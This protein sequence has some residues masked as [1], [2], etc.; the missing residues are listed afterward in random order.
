MSRR[1]SIS[2]IMPAYNAA[3]YIREALDS[4]FAQT[5]QPDEV[6]VVENGST[7]ETGQILTEYPVRV[8]PLA[9]NIGPCLATNLAVAASRTDLVALLDA[10]DIW[11]PDHLE[12]TGALMDAS[13]DVV[14][15]CGGMRS[16]GDLEGEVIPW[17]PREAFDALEEVFA[18]TAIPPHSASVIRRDAFITVGGHDTA[19]WGA[20]DYDLELRLAAFG[21]FASSGAVT[22]LYRH[23]EGQMSRNAVRQQ[24]AVH[25]ARLRVVGQLEALRDPR[26]PALRE[27]MRR[28]W[29]R[30]L[31]ISWK[32]GR[33]ARV[34]ALLDLASE[35]SFASPGAR[36]GLR[37]ASVTAPLL[38]FASEHVPRSIRSRAKRAWL[39]K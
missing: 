23:H 30:D 16:F 36:L 31:K 28:L 18:G 19:Y 14:L 6:I 1:L 33:T 10:D 2:A 38:W 37:A 35:S 32:R 25:R 17:P 24:I 9:K 8:I 34:R 11:T 39:G 22:M 21:K 15:A 26:G 29:R 27:R 4:A 5:R 7:D 12:R 3:G 13:S 20:H